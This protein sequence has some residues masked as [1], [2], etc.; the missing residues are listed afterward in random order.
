MRGARGEAGLGVHTAEGAR[1][2]LEILFVGDGVVV[3]VHD[4]LVA[5]VA[6]GKIALRCTE[7][8]AL[9]GAVQVP[10]LVRA[11]VVGFELGLGSGLEERPGAAAWT[12]L[13]EHP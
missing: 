4:D 1:H 12:R 8:R 7:L 6:C 10:D 2:Q 3:D 5:R 13:R 11:R 9:D